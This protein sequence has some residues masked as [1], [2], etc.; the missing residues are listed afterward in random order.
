MLFRKKHLIRKF[1]SVMFDGFLFLLAC[2]SALGVVSGQ[3]LNQSVTLMTDMLTGYDRRHRPV[4]DQSKP[5]QVS[6]L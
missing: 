1:T 5:I 4:E 3:T 2:G 6:L